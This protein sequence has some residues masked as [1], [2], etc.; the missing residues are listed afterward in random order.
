MANINIGNLFILNYLLSYL[1]NTVASHRCVCGRE[2]CDYMSAK[3]VFISKK[4]K[5]LFK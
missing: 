2:C 1:T 4:N 5:V 3:I